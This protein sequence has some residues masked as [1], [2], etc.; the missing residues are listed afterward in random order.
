MVDEELLRPSREH[1][2]ALNAQIA[3]L[4]SQTAEKVENYPYDDKGRYATE[5]WREFYLTIE[6][7]RRERDAVGKVIADYYGL[8]A[9]PT[10]VVY[11]DALGQG[12]RE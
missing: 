6:P 12:A 1:L 10:I 5:C 3:T 8:Q 7:L 4:Q 9:M 2:A 11:T